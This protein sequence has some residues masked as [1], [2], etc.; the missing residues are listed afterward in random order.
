M[1][2]SVRKPTQTTGCSTCK[3]KSTCL[4]RKSC[5]FTTSNLWI[6]SFS[7]NWSIE[8]TF[9]ARSIYSHNCPRSSKRSYQCPLKV[10]PIISRAPKIP[11]RISTWPG[12]QLTWYI[13]IQSKRKLLKLPQERKKG[14][15]KR[16]KKPQSKEMIKLNRLMTTWWLF[17]SPRSRDRLINRWRIKSTST[18]WQPRLHSQTMEGTLSNSMLSKHRAGETESTIEC[19]LCYRKCGESASLRRK[20]S[21]FGSTT[22]TRVSV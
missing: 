15:R 3:N 4:P 8:E 18:V 7:R 21:T 17:W 1:W 6:A 13:G 22:S 12:K 9:P 14:S 11:L 19:S 16:L 5:R 2:T 20:N 10:L